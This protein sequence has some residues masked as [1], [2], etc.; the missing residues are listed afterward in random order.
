M[1]TSKVVSSTAHGK[2][3][4][5]SW[6]RFWFQPTDPTTLGLMRVIT[7]L[8]VLYVHLVYCF[9]LQSFFGKHAWLDLAAIDKDARNPRPMRCPGIITGRIR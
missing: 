4:P 9:D 5:G 8:I 1:S 6:N 3:T 2:R 7:G